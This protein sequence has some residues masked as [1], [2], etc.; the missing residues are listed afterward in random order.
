M[1]KKVLSLILCLTILLSCFSA[2]TVSAS[3]AVVSAKSLFT[4]STTPVDNNKLTYKISVT[5][6]Q[7]NIAG[8]ILVVEYDSTVLKP[9]NCG[10][11][12]RTNSTEGTVQNFAGNF[13]YGVTEQNKNMYSIA[14]MNT[15]SV[16]TPST[17][18][19]FFN[20]QF[21][22]MDDRH[23]STDINFYCK[24]YYSTSE[25]DKTI[26]VEDG[27][28]EIRFFEDVSTLEAPVTKSATPAND[29]LKV[30]WEPVVGADGY[31]IYRKTSGTDWAMVG[32]AAGENTTEYIDTGL[33]SGYTYIYSVSAANY[34][35]ESLRDNIGVSCKYVAKPVI[36][37]L[38]NV[39]GGVQITW[40]GTY[41][42]SFYNVMRREFGEIEW[43][44]INSRS[45]TVTPTYKDT[46]VENGKFY[47]Y[48][49]ISGTD[50][51]ESIP[52]EVG[53]TI[54]Y[55]AAPAASAVNTVDGIRLDWP[56]NPY[57]TRYEILRKSV[58]IQNS[59]EVYDET[60]NNYYVDANVE[61][62]K[63]YT[64]AVK[65]YTN[66]SVSAYNTSGYTITCVPPARVDSLTLEKFSVRI[67]W[68]AVKNAS[69][70][71][72]YRKPAD[73]GQWTKIGTATASATAF[74]DTSV[75]SGAYYV[76]SVCPVISNSVSAKMESGAIYFIKAPGN[77]VAAN[78]SEGIEV[79]WERSLGAVEYKIYRSVNGGVAE[80]LTTVNAVDGTKFLDN[81][82]E[83]GNKYTYTIKAMSDTQN[84]LDSDDSNTLIRISSIGKTTPEIA[85]GGVLVKW[86]AVENVQNYAVFRTSGEG[87]TQVATVDEAQYLDTRVISDTVYSYAVAAIVEGS[88]GVADMEESIAILYVAPPASITITN[89][90]ASSTV[91]WGQVAGA[92]GYE[93][94][95][96]KGGAESEFTLVNSVAGDVLSFVDNDVVSGETY[97]YKI[98]C[99]TIEGYS[100]MSKGAKNVFLSIP[101]ISSIANSYTGI[102]FSWN[103]VEGADSYRVYRKIYGEKY[104][105]YITTVSAD[106]LSYNDTET[107]NGK[108]MCYTVKAMNG[109]SAS[110]YLARCM[111]AVDAPVL[112]YSNSPSGVY[113]KWDKNDAAVGYW[114]Y[115]KTP[116]AKYW[117]RIACVTTTY[118]TDKN[119]KS[120]TDYIYTAKAYTGKIL[121]SYNADGWSLKHLSTPVITS[122]A[123]G[124]GA[125][126]CSWKAVPGA[127]AYYVY[128]KADG[129]AN[130][131]YIAKTTS[132]L[133]RDTNVKN[134]STYTYTVKAYHGVNVS[135]FNYSGVSAKYITAPTVKVQN[136]I[137]GV[138]LSWDKVSGA[139]SYYVYRK[140]GNAKS[141]TMIATVTKTNYVDTKV[142]SGTVYTYTVK[143]YAN[144]TLSGCNLYGW[145]TYFLTT[146]KI[147]SV[148]S[149]PSGV[150]IRWEK[151]PG[152]TWYSIY[153]KGT[154]G[155]WTRIGT[156]TGN[157]KVTYIDKTAD[158]NKRY[159]Y[160]V[161]A[162]Y[163]S[164]ISSYYTGQKVT[165]NY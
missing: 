164:Y 3:A 130:W 128:R 154:T 101:Q 63:G 60:V 116:S 80:E 64:Y 34:Y 151:V 158:K 33:E 47:E 125:L 139:S 102:T 108:I 109:S 133:Y 92:I 14:Y 129:A 57:A 69:A 61:A 160:T 93:V 81:T 13:V 105:T 18:T 152:A 23:P 37:S 114:I 73:G 122:V 84:S 24:E 62:G 155:T 123:R 97:V 131:T 31:V 43:V 54:Y 153:R 137:S 90:T 32:T 126:T 11:A 127:A 86:T 36:I 55:V 143:A 99:K 41:G 107:T 91:T 52:A 30:T 44:K 6:N 103:P 142:K 51:F 157:N 77:I 104:W 7:K 38:E 76:Y 25:A 88:R 35:G 87:W 28:Q 20:M 4:V 124:Y 94:Y 16:S 17:A 56:N 147:V 136:N 135:S 12:K 111:T 138:S 78:I 50:S 53:A 45:A 156:T 46:T 165:V 1:V 26:S 10:P 162:C 29:G 68:T 21:E 140:A 132:T 15:L 95:R 8:T 119:V 48:D 121:S 149:Y 39:V 19:E 65:T 150:N 59:L 70:Y 67:E 113:L 161:R 71:V 85:D 98:R 75:V 134:G 58:G 2:V 42:A 49:I 100:A 74:S 118:Y 9:V 5:A 110:A 163:G 115:R 148:L 79:T 83:F 66:D 112:A 89:N 82:V 22:I 96:A 106:T 117:T 27:L 72:I 144:K 146:P 159:T 40:E 141:W 120:G 145:K